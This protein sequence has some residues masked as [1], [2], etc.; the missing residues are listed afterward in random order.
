MAIQDLFSAELFYAGT[1]EILGL[2]L[3]YTE[4]QIA[5][6]T[7]ACQQLAK[8]IHD[9]IVAVDWT[10]FLSLE[11]WIYGVRVVCISDAV[12]NTWEEPFHVAGGRLEN[13]APDM[14]TALIQLTGTPADLIPVQSRLQFSCVPISA[15]VQN[16]LDT[17]WRTDFQLKFKAA[18]QFVDGGSQGQWALAIPHK[19]T[20][21]ADPV[22]VVAESVVIQA[23]AGSR[24]DRKPNTPN[25]G[26]KPEPI[27]VTLFDGE[28]APKKKR[29]RRTRAELAAARKKL[30]EGGSP[31]K[32]LPVKKGA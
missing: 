17:T 15:V 30:L 25:T 16:T 14:V 3:T 13:P 1:E 28:Q 10:A 7:I 12:H 20:P 26:R 31:A 29:K 24:Y 9:A 22:G 27:E 19:S 11:T 4:S 2:N 8:G 6:P 5:D 18:L 21:E 23:G 32:T